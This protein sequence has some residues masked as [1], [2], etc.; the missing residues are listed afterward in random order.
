MEP[1][2][3]S[4]SLSKDMRIDVLPYAKEKASLLLYLP[5]L[6]NYI[7]FTEYEQ[8]PIDG[9]NPNKVIAYI[10]LLY[11]S[12]S[13]LT[14]HPMPDL[15]DRME[16]AAELVGF[17][18]TANKNF[19]EPVT[20]MLFPLKDEEG[21][22]LNMVFEFLIKENNL[23]WEEIVATERHRLNCIYSLMDAKYNDPK[24]L[25]DKKDLRNEIASM[26]ADLKRKYSDMF[27]KNEDLIA[28]G[29]EVVTNDFIED[30]AV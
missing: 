30:R 28:K 27:E 24:S 20:K 29:R 7:S 12:D 9:L 11:S 15:K 22:L 23:E 18:K 3:T 17:K 26:T 2:T 1:A 25:K 8:N 21:K 5:E 10:V 16:R 6:A 19:K 4:E 13:I 14:G